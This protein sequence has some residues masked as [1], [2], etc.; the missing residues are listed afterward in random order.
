M[1]TRW[2]AWGLAASVTCLVPAARG[3]DWQRQGADRGMSKYTPGNVAV[4]SP[5]HLRY[6]KRF[7]SRFT[8]NK[9]NFFYGYAVVTHGG[10][11]VIFADDRSPTPASP[12]YC[13]GMKFNW[14]TGQ[15]LAYYMLGFYQLN[16]HDREIDSHHYTNPIIWHGDARCI[17]AGR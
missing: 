14:L 2:I 3:V 1:R 13:S 17:R 4:D 10:Q 11:A 6:T 8:D 16:E 12:N 15:S 7:Y 9:G 5:L